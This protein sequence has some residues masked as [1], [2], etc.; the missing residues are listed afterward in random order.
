M[1]QFFI[2][3]YTVKQETQMRGW[4]MMQFLQKLETNQLM[5]Y[6]ASTTKYE[7]KKDGTNRGKKGKESKFL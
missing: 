2:V 3:S 7:S 6:F 5:N 4:I 1:L